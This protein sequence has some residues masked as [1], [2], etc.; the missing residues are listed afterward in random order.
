LVRYLALIGSS[1][2]TI[3]MLLVGIFGILPIIIGG[4]DPT[5]YNQRNQLREDINII[6]VALFIARIGII[7]IFSSTLFKTNILLMLGSIAG[8]FVFGW[9]GINEVYIVSRLFPRNTYLSISGMIEIATVI[10]AI[11]FAIGCLLYYKKSKMIVI[12][13]GLILIYVLF[14]TFFYSTVVNLIFKYEYTIERSIFGLV[15]FFFEKVLFAFAGWY[16]SFSNTSESNK[17]IDL[18]ESTFDFNSNF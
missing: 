13:G 2:S 5:V 15:F 11:L 9:G 8:I 6:S 12:A 18:M 14:Y 1:I 7:M 16:I 3:S 4:I 10:G 17:K